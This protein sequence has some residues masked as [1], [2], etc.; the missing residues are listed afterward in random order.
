MEFDNIKSPILTSLDFFAPSIVIFS[1]VSVIYFS[2]GLTSPIFIQFTPS[3]FVVIKFFIGLGD[4][5]LMIVAIS[6]KFLYSTPFGHNSFISS[7][8][9][10]IY[11]TSISAIISS[12]A[13]LKASS[14]ATI[15]LISALSFTISIFSLVSSAST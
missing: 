6:P 10:L 8:N 2:P 4:A 1:A 5:P 9:L 14:R 15:S 11:S 12:I 7:S 13:F 3:L